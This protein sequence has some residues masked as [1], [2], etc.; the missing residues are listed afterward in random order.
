MI[1]TMPV[2]HISFLQKYHIR[3]YIPYGYLC[4]IFMLATYVINTL[5]RACLFI[6]VAL[7]IKNIYDT[8]ET[9]DESLW[10][11]MM[12]TFGAVITEES[13]FS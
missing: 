4:Y 5:T 1:F 2:S 6:G 7:L 10:H 13:M 12:K 11:F 9:E 3:M 8:M